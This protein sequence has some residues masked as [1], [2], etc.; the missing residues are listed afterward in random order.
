MDEPS[1]LFASKAPAMQRIR[2]TLAYMGGRYAGWQLQ[3]DAPTV[4]GTLE[5]ALARVC[6][7]QVRVHGAARTDAGVHALGQTAHCDIPRAKLDIPLRRGLNALLPPSICVTAVTPVAPSFH[8][9]YHATGKVYA[10]SLWTEFDYV[11]PQRRP[12][13][14]RRSGLDLEAMD[15][16]A[17]HFVGAR[18]FKSFQNVG[19]PVRSTVRTVTDFHRCPGCHPAEVVWRIRAD[20]FLKQM[21]RNIMGCLVAVGLGKLTPEDIPDLL[22]AR[23][24]ALAPETAP[25]EGLCLEE[26]LYKH[27]ES[28]SASEEPCAS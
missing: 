20:G 5:A 9:R 24:R 12:F 25:A 28:V 3:P 8:A 13:V 4:Q 19:T 15:A 14:W 21:V 18:D 11:L 10:Y 17:L 27:P 7:Q 23:D 2:L 22:T 26:V 6:G 1:K 16:A